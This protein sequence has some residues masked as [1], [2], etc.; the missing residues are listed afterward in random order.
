MKILTDGILTNKVY[1]TVYYIG[2]VR[3]ADCFATLCNVK[4]K[5]TL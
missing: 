2:A 4:L 1:L 5:S 3:F